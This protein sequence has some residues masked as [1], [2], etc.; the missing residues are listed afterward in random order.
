M[1]NCILRRDLHRSK[2][3]L[4]TDSMPVSA[5]HYLVAVLLGVVHKLREAL[6]APEDAPD[7]LCTDV[8][9]FFV[10]GL[11]NKNLI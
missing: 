1:L 3:G 4:K 5:S 9:S 10:V 11:V 6:K 7:R 8:S 2:Q